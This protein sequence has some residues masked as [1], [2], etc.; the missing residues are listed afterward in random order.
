MPEEYQTQDEI[1]FGDKA[2][3]G[4][5]FLGIITMDEKS[6]NE[7]KDTPTEQWTWAVRPIRGNMNV[8]GKTGSLYGKA[9]KSSRA[10]SK[11]MKVLTDFNK[12]F[13][14]RHKDSDPRVEPRPDLSGQQRFPRQGHLVGLVAKFVMRTYSFGGDFTARA[15]PIPVALPDAEELEFA[16][17][18]PAYVPPE[19]ISSSEPIPTSTTLDAE[20]LENIATWVGGMTPQEVAA[21]AQSQPDLD[22]EVRRTVM[23][24]AG[25]QAA[26]SAGLLTLT[27]AGRYERVA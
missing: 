21:W 9:D 12:V 11:Y 25:A 24:G 16:R 27:K 13:G 8:K 7:F 26:I 6:W 18:V 19:D 20:T 5:P 2:T 1:G 14:A 10:N 15:V 17:S 4:E 23:S 3:E 22:K